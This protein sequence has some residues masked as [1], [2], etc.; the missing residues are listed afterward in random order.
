ML[1]SKKSEI[2]GLFFGADSRA[3]LE[4]LDLRAA[5]TNSTKSRFW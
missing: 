2:F 1:G 5:V 4:G 3:H